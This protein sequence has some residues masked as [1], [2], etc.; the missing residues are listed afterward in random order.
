MDENKELKISS[1][2]I[3]SD[4]TIFENLHSSFIHPT[5]FVHSSA[6]VGDEEG[7]AVVGES[8]WIGAQARV[9]SG[10]QLCKWSILGEKAKIGALAVIGDGSIVSGGVK[11][12]PA[13]KIGKNVWLGASV[14]VL[15]G[16]IIPDNSRVSKGSFICPEK[17]K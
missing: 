13:A 8:A 11:V 3:N 2:H 4:G 6:K 14:I 17:Y 1:T 16:T 12:G 10:A 5:S 15:E 9:S 7:G